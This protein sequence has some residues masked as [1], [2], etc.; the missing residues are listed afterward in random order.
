MKRSSATCGCGQSQKIVLHSNRK[1]RLKTPTWKL[2]SS[3]KRRSTTILKFNSLL[4]FSGFEMR[5]K[6]ELLEVLDRFVCKAASWSGLLTAKLTE[7]KSIR[8]NNMVLNI[9]KSVLY[10]FQFVFFWYLYVAIWLRFQI[11]FVEQ[12]LLIAHCLILDN[13]PF[14]NKRQVC[15]HRV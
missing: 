10:Y 13:K 1:L 9:F 7:N 15:V 2:S 11:L 14:E 4:Q 8:L 3:K 5:P 6:P 12:A